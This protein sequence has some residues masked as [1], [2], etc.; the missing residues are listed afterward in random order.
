MPDPLRESTGTI[1]SR[2]N[3]DS[4]CSIDTTWQAPQKQTHGLQATRKAIACGVS[5]SMEETTMENKPRGVFSAEDEF[6]HSCNSISAIGD[7]MTS[8]ANSNCE[9]ANATLEKIEFV[10]FR[11]SENPKKLYYEMVEGEKAAK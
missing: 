11:E 4:A 9:L 10:C 1:L 8:L 2:L 7:L 3:A 6:C 5:I